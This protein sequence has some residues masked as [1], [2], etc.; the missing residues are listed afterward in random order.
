MCSLNVLAADSDPAPVF[1]NQK[2]QSL[3]KVLTRK[4]LSKVFRK[5]RQGESVLEQPLYKFM[6][7]EELQDALED[8]NK[9][10]DDFLQMPP[11]L[12]A[13]KPKNTVLSYDPALEGLE[14]SPLVFT[15]ISF[16]VPNSKRLIVVREPDGTLREANWEVRDRI[17]QSYFPSPGR[18]ILCPK[19]FDGEYLND[20]LA[21]EEFIYILDRA[22]AQFEPDDPKFQYVTSSTYEYINENLVFEKLR[23]TR[24]FGPLVFYLVWHD[25]IDNL[26]LELIETCHVEE[27]KSL[28]QL[29]S[30]VKKV[31]FGFT[32]TLDLLEEY[33][34]KYSKKRG[35]LE[36]ALQTF[37][38]LEHKKK[39]VQIAN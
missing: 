38:D 16:G 15:D 32:D 20:L 31:E 30:I 37:K 34:S 36:L 22:C 27:A 29:Y 26:L 5:V 3:L 7:D 6:T 33:V 39:S 4:D 23:S 17:N 8:A 9:K 25:D 13:R 24:H 12:A 1:L 10:S 19:M 35:P 21:R 14:T 18:E 28:L 2:V 11:V